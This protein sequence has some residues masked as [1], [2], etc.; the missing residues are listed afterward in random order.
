MSERQF[1][2]QIDARPVDDD[3]RALLEL[4]LAAV[5]LDVPASIVV[6]G[7]AVDLFDPCSDSPWLQLTEQDLIEVHAVVADDQELP[8]GVERL[9]HCRQAKLAQACTVIRV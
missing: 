1:L 9:D 2:I 7:D 4:V 6:A 5:S 8:V 3:S